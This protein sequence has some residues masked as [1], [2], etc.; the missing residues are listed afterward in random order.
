MHP[1]FHFILFA[2]LVPGFATVRLAR[3]D[4]ADK[5]AAVPKASASLQRQ[6]DELKAGQ[7]QLL[8]ELQEIKQLLRQDT[9]RSEVLAMPETPPVITQNVRGEPFRGDARAPVAVIEFS[10]FNCSFC[11]RFAT[12]IFPQFERDYLATGKVKFYFRDLPDPHDPDAWRKAQA[13]RC[14]GE[15][16]KFWEMHDRLFMNQ[17]LLSVPEN[18]TEG[19]VQSLGLDPE[20]FNLCLH[21]E[22]YLEAI[23]RSAAG[24]GR[25]GIHGTPAFLIGTVSGNGE[26][27]RATEVV[28]G[29]ESY[30]AFRTN[31]D[32]FL[33][34]PKAV[35]Q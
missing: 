28:L 29:A 6:I 26:V 17:A 33:G 14:A 3:A 15:Q 20:K 2:A 25:L 32:E 30:E 12:E 10:D 24:A 4:P 9:A 19:P 13:A 34:S 35:S 16:G 18:A 11:A 1:G 27:V 31:V 8:K 23:R 5:S 21:S 7:R 22:R